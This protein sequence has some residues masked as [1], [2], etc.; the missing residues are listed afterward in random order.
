MLVVVVLVVVGLVRLLTGGDDPA[1]TAAQPAA[2]S[3]PSAVPTAEPTAEPTRKVRT[4]RMVDVD[5]DLASSGGACAADAVGVQ[6]AVP[7]GAYADGPVPVRLAFTTTSTRACTLDLADVDLIVDVANDDGVSLW[8]TQ[9][10]PDAVPQ[11]SVQLD[12]TW[13]TSVDLTWSGRR[14]GDDCADTE[15]FLPAKTYEVRAAVLGGEPGTAEA[16]LRTRP[17]PT[18]TP[19]PKPSATPSASPSTSATPTPTPT[20]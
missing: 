5:V 10:C 4:R 9:V 8:S 11:R 7:G 13:S 3:T 17:K 20:D 2:S 6:P 12:P 1:P 14:G 16:V 15:R 19:S 18:P